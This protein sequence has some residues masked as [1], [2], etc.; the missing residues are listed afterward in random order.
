MSLPT[1]VSEE[2]FDEFYLSRFG[3]T[4]AS[5]K[6]VLAQGII[7]KAGQ[8]ILVLD[9]ATGQVLD[10]SGAASALG[11]GASA[12]LFSRKTVGQAVASSVTLVNDLQLVLPVAANST[13]LFELGLILSEN[14]GGIDA[15][16]IV[17]SGAIAYGNWLVLNGSDLESIAVNVTTEAQIASSLGGNSLAVIQKFI[18]TTA[19][20]AGNVQLQFAQ[21]SSNAAESR[22]Q[23]GSWIKAE[24][25]A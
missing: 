11:G 12:A 17:P 6:P 13:Y 15:D 25:V 18:V 5:G 16:I 1:P 14:G 3:K 20:T 24:K 2:N 4:K 9:E 21:T 8:P 7:K 23:A 22:I 19:S 10:S